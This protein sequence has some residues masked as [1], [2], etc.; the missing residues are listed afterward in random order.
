MQITKKVKEQNSNKVINFMDGISFEVSPI[1]TL[2]LVTASSF[3]SEPSYYRTNF[4][5]N[6]YFINE[7]YKNDL[8][9]LKDN[10]GL[11]TTEIM[12]KV[13]DEALEYDF[14]ATLEWA[15]VLRNNYYMRLNPQVILVRAAT[16]HKRSNF[17]KNNPT[18][19]KK[20]ANK[21][22]LR[23]D[24]P[25]SGLTYYLFKNRCKNNLPNILKNI[26][27]IKLESL[28][29]FELNKY[30][31]SHIGIKD[32]IKI[33]HANSGA[34]D[35]LFKAKIKVS[36]DNKTWINKKSEGKNWSKILESNRIGH[37]ALLRNLNGIFYEITDKNR[38]DDLLHMLED[39]VIKGKQFPFR[40]YQAYKVLEKHTLDN[41]TA[42]LDSLERCIDI[43]M[44]NM[45]ILRGNT[46]CLTDNS[47]S[48]WGAFTSE[49]GKNVIAEINNLSSVITAINSENGEVIKFGDTIKNYPVSRRNGV[50]YQTR[51]ISENKYTDVGGNTEHGIWEFFELALRCSIKYDNIFIYSDQQ[52]GHDELYGKDYKEYDDYRIGTY[53]DV[54]KLIKKYRSTVNANV[55][56]FSIQTAGYNNVVIPEYLYKTYILQGWTG[57]ELLFADAVN[58]ISKEVKIN[59]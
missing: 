49:Y 2:K 56:V 36:E 50:L 40:Y 19:F 12:E 34:I 43:S 39:G 30:K 7:R 28:N 58:A 26:W 21:I 53:I 22:I 25:A 17:N 1:T 35:N 46:V 23:G 38:V 11:S 15:V 31:N 5:D 57:K 8:I 20:I 54:N 52:A 29:E 42:I 55:N 6:I 14:K 37:Q 48:C 27:K 59:Q 44:S 3:F 4:K 9:C 13:I 18:F 16:H 24:E 47:G 51:F 45:P 33:T 10:C 41:K 32:T